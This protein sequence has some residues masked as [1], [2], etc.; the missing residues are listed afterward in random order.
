MGRPHEALEID[1]RGDGRAE[2]SAGHPARLFVRGGSVCL[3]TT[4]RDGG[5]PHVL[6][7]HDDGWYDTG[8]LAVPDGRGG[9][10]LVGRTADRS[11]SAAGFAARPSCPHRV[12]SSAVRVDGAVPDAKRRAQPWEHHW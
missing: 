12:R 10:R 4:G 3:A 11:C 7:D 9:I 1:L 8:D 2:I 5:D 6:A